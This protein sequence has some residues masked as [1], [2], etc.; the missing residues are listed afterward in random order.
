[1]PTPFICRHNG[2]FRETRLSTKRMATGGGGEQGDDVTNAEEE[3]WLQIKKKKKEKK[4]SLLMTLSEKKKNELFEQKKLPGQENRQD[5]TFGNKL[6]QQKQVIL[7]LKQHVYNS[8]EC[9]DLGI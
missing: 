2:L 7:F 3:Q 8:R 9:N 6:Q 4:T 1:M 5:G